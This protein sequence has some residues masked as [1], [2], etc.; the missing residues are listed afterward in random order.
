LPSR[1]FSVQATLG[2]DSTPS[3][4][5]SLQTLHH[6]PE[7]FCTSYS[8]SGIHSITSQSFFCISY[9]WLGLNTITLRTLCH[10][11][12]FSPLPSS[13]FSP[14]PT[15]GPDSTPSID[16]IPDTSQIYGIFCLFF[17]FAGQ[18]L[19]VCIHFDDNS[20]LGPWNVTPLHQ[21]QSHFGHSV[22]F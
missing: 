4:A 7:F 18:V 22:P 21:F 20:T 2:P 13:F 9:A 1:V 12:E 5:I 16:L 17:V 19:Y 10:F 3:T 6:C 14:P 11:L 15:T 8:R